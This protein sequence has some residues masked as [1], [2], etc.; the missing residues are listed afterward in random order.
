MTTPRRLPGIRIDVTPPP[1]AEV[2]PRMDVAVFVGFASTGP[3]HRPVAIE[4]VL[5]Y[6]MVFG[7]DAPLA[8]DRESGERV[9]AYLGATVRAFFSNGGRRCWVIRVARTPEFEA[10]CCKV[11]GKTVEPRELAVA[12]RFTLPGILVLSNREKSLLP[13]MVQARSVGSWSDDLRVQTALTITAFELK[14]YE[15]LTTTRISFHSTAS[16]QIGDLIELD[17]P[18][19]S[20]TG[21]IRRYAIVDATTVE[22]LSKQVKARL[23]ATFEPAGE[24]PGSLSVE[25][26]VEIFGD[27]VSQIPATFKSV[28][29]SEF[30]TEISFTMNRSQGLAQGQWVRF[31]QSNAMPIIWLQ[32]DKLNSTSIQADTNQ[33]AVVVIGQAWR[34]FPQD[35]LIFPATPITRATLL[36]LVLRVMTGQTDEV[37]RLQGVGLTTTHRAAWW[38]QK[39]DAIYYATP[40]NQTEPR[41]QFPLAALD[42]KLDIDSSLAWIPLG[43]SALFG[44][45]LAPLHQ[46]A[47]PLER[48]GLSRL[49][50]ELFLDPELDKLSIDHLIHQAD[51]IR[52]LSNTPREL[53]GIHAAL[54]IGT[55]GMFN[56]ASLVAIPDALHTGW[57]K[58]SLV[59]L[60]T[61]T[62]IKTASPAHWY[63]HRSSCHTNSSGVELTEPD[64]SRFLDCSTHKLTQPVWLNQQPF[65]VPSGVFRLTWESSESNAAVLLEEALQTDFRDA[66]ELYLGSNNWFDVNATH[67]GILFYR[68][69]AISGDERST[70]SNTLKVTV[71][72]DVWVL[73]TAEEYD[74]NDKIEKDKIEFGATNLLSIHRSLLRLA[75]ATGELFVVLGLPYHYRA[76]DAIRYVSRLRSSKLT[77]LE[78]FDDNERRALSYGAIYH[79]WIVSANAQRFYPPDGITTGILAARATHRGAWVAPA[80]ELFRDVSALTPFIES[81]AYLALQN[82]QINLIRADAR[83]FLTLSAD[84]LSDEPEWRPINVRR[85]FILLRRLALRRGISYV[86]EPNNDVLQ[87]AVERGFTFLLTDMFRRGAFAGATPVESFRVVTSGANKSTADRDAGCF[88]VELQVAPSLPLQFLTIRLSQSGERFTVLEEI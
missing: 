36:T 58:R 71:R 47:T 46:T 42:E 84:T 28:S 40:E 50:A 66:R 35:N 25:G 80:N 64:F 82:A 55:G 5:E 32:I 83:G 13:A 57:V 54:S 86:F 16:L 85:L 75:S 56:E 23:C 78:G 48:D 27:T 51:V 52:F 45:A 44:E 9:F 18:T 76:A 24:T 88:F 31:L 14:D 37:A 11:S 68:L 65:N 2:L 34:E 22:G 81:S 79:P 38:Q 41:V 39:S 17:D 10:I 12:N 7:K 67:E 62:P 53:F 49:D 73:R 20:S 30:Y 59:D 21:K 60:P 69:T 77:D 6:T 15:L 1:L 4:S 29:A 63:T 26:T 3:T 61:D 19:P 70:I 72:D 33:L 8:Y 87:R 43:V 74:N